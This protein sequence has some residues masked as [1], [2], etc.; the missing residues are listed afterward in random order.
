MLTGEDG[1]TI[2]FSDVVQA[3]AEIAA[4]NVRLAEQVADLQR[5]TRGGEFG[6]TETGETYQES[7]NAVALTD[8]E[9]PARSHG[10]TRSS[11]R[12]AP[13]DGRFPAAAVRFR[14][15]IA[16]ASSQAPAS[17][18]SKLAASFDPAEIVP[19][20]LADA[21]N[22]VTDDPLHNTGQVTALAYD[23]D[24]GSLIA[25]LDIRDPEVAS[26]MAQGLM[27]GY[28]AMISKKTGRLQK[29]GLSLRPAAGPVAL[30]N[31][32]ALSDDDPDPHLGAPPGWSP[33]WGAWLWGAQL[34]PRA[35][36]SVRE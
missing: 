29:I 7:T 11:A 3:V 8:T 6:L 23:P 28:Q 16:R 13:E 26:R 35:V 21:Q 27:G 32:V 4:Q 30:I 14:R 36:P 5:P 18:L 22:R 31:T 19:V 9:W 15:C 33:C 25:E 20:P 24:N 34:Q 10:C 17:Q 12:C 1:T 2:G